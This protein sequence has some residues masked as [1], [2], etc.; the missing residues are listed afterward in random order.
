MLCMLSRQLIVP[1]SL[2]IRTP[3]PVCSPAPIPNCN[4]PWPLGAKPPP[5]MSAAEFRKE[6]DRCSS[7]TRAGSS[8][9]HKS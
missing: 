9:D 1:R 5:T 7:E 2:C 8:S 6:L 3:R 4:Q